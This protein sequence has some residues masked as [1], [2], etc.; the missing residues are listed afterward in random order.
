MFQVV[1]DAGQN[2]VFA[3]DDGYIGHSFSK[4]RRPQSCCHI[5]KEKS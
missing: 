1:D 2:D 5:E 3:G 4:G